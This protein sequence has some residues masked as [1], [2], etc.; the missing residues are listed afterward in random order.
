[1]SKIKQV[2]DDIEDVTN[3]PTKETYK[4]THQYDQELTKQKIEDLKSNRDLRE[5][6]AKLCVGFMCVWSLIVWILVIASGFE[7]LC[8]HYS[9]TVLVSIIGGSTVN[10]IGLVL[11]IMKGLFPPS[12]K[13]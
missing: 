10:V 6:Y 3:S 1:M 8:I 2:R 7:S 12:M 13:E 5:T 11:V 9:D 4:E